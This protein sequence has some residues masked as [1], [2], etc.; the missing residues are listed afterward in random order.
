MY[1][2]PVQKAKSQFIKQFIVGY[3][4]KTDYFE[5]FSREMD[6][7]SNIWWQYFYNNVEYYKNFL[8]IRENFDE[9]LA[10]NYDSLDI[11][12]KNKELVL[13]KFLNIDFKEKKYFPKLNSGKM[14]N[15][16]TFRKFF[17]FILKKNKFNK[18]IMLFKN[19]KKNLQLKI[20]KKRINNKSLDF[21]FKKSLDEYDKLNDYLKKYEILKGIYIV[22]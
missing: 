12:I 20:L 21:K 19:I 9:V 1:R 11:F 2:N 13:K 10:V 3:E 22:K 5:A 4:K 14:N 6:K 18:I 17:N 8:K 7:D 16:L 15:D